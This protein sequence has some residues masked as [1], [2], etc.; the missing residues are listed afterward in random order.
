MCIRVHRAREIEK[1][2]KDVSEYTYPEN[3]GVSSVVAARYQARG[4]N[5]DNHR[6]RHHHRH[7]HGQ[8]DTP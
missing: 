8:R 5:D 4:H 1:W 2:G 3:R 6:R 7:L